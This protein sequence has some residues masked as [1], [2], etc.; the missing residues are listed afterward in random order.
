MN[1]P[2]LLD[3]A[4]LALAGLACWGAWR[5]RPA[6]PAA[7]PPAPPPASGPGPDPSDADRLLREGFANLMAYRGPITHKEDR[8]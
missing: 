5:P 7:P 1:F 4:T 8:E 3:L 2:M 6:P